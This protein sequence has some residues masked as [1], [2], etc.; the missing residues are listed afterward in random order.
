M[1]SGRGEK[2]APH[3]IVKGISIGLLVFILVSLRSIPVQAT[4]GDW[5]FGTFYK[6]SYS[7]GFLSGVNQLTV[8]FFNN[9]M[10][11]PSGSRTFA[12]LTATFETPSGSNY[13]PQV[14][15]L[16][17]QY[18]GYSGYY[19]YGVLM[20]SGGSLVIGFGNVKNGQGQYDGEYINQVSGLSD[21]WHTIALGTYTA[22]V[23]STNYLYLGWYLDGTAY[24]NWQFASCTTPCSFGSNQDVTNYV[25]PNMSAESYDFTSTDFSSMDI[26]GYFQNS[27]TSLGPVYLYPATWGSSSAGGDCSIGSYQTSGWTVGDDNEP[28]GTGTVPPETG[29]VYDAS[30]GA[31]DEWGIGNGDTSGYTTVDPADLSSTFCSS[32]PPQIA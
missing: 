4:S 8:D 28:P 14:S 16:N 26:H 5:A 29:H 25:V 7:S 31:T 2:H 1:R 24:A 23:G 22:V 19:L 10:P 13:I 9:G 18:N 15:I 21:S 6:G 32:G 20:N 27:G 30:W 17:T 11:A 3:S 12:V